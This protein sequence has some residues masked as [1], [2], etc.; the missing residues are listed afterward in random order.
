MSL[1]KLQLLLSSKSAFMQKWGLSV[2][3]IVCFYQ[4]KPEIW[5]FM[6]NLPILKELATVVN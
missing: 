2:G 6:K 5:I 1:G 3:Q 4:E